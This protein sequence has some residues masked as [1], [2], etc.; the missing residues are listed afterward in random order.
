MS[1]GGCCDDPTHVTNRGSDELVAELEKAMDNVASAAEAEPLLTR[2][3]V[4]Y[5]S[6]TF[7][8]DKD[9]TNM[10][11]ATGSSVWRTGDPVH[12]TDE[13]YLEVGLHL[14]AASA[15]AAPHPGKRG[16]LDSL[17][18]GQPN[19]KRRGPEVN[20][21]PWVGGLDAPLRE[22]GRGRG[23]GFRGR[24]TPRGFCGR[25]GAAGGRGHWRN[26]GRGGCF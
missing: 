7:S 17:V 16:R 24:W 25:G 21:P 6:D 9:L 1:Q 15:E 18:T 22:R 12:L 2:D 3:S 14:L 19:K 23:R 20:P 5:I 4:Y 11:T 10:V 8:Y 26:R 13:A